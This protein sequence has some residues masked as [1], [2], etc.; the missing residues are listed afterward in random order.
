MTSKLNPRW[1]AVAL[2]WLA[3]LIVSYLNLTLIQEITTIR[4][5]NDRLR[6]EM[7]FQH[8]HAAQL[9]R[10]QS[11]LASC[12]LPVASAKLGLES[13]RSRLYGL[14]A[15]LGLNG[16]IMDAQMDQAMENRLPLRLKMEGTFQQTANLMASLKSLPYLALKSS[17]VM[18]AF[19]EPEAQIELEFDFQ[20]TVDPAQELEIRTLQAAADPLNKKAAGR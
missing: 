12:Y 17:R 14:A 2:I 11:I 18:V 6:K 10:V 19:P 3:A 9:D 7:L 20:L 15:H 5:E 13:V 16:V 1:S 4:E 8:H